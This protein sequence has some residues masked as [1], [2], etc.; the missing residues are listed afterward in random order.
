MLFWAAKKPRKDAIKMNGAA[1]RH[2]GDSNGTLDT[3]WEERG[4]ANCRSFA[5]RDSERGQPIASWITPISS[6]AISSMVGWSG[7]SIMTR[8]SGSVPL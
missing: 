7:P 6:A 1:N 3:T 2:Q 8:A 5:A 4:A